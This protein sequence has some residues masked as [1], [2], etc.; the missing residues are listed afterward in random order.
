VTDRNVNAIVSEL[1]AI[2]LRQLAE[3]DFDS[4]AHTEHC[5][6]QAYATGTRFAAETITTARVTE[7]SEQL[8]ATRDDLAYLRDHWKEVLRKAAEKRDEDLEELRRSHQQELEE[9]DEFVHSEVPV[10]YRKLSP[11]LL[12]MRQRQH[13]M[14]SSKRY[15]EAKILKDE[16]DALEAKEN[17]ENRQKW[18]ARAEVDKRTLMKRQQERMSIRE[19]TWAKEIRG[20]E[21]IAQREILNCLRTTEHLEGKIFDKEQFAV[22]VGWLQ[23]E[24]TKACGGVSAR[25]RTMKPTE[26][27]KAFKQKRMLNKFVYSP[28]FRPKLPGSARY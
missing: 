6:R 9:F 12:Q 11:T 27:V 2:E 26:A 19:A 8:A 20:I 14:G 15:V 16:A 5:L 4:A 23:P 22:D 3:E 24:Q 25:A 21:R 13:A 18:L 28:V 10:H 7:I 17:E 1:R